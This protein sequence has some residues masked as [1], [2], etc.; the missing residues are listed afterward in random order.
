MKRYKNLDV[1]KGLMAILVIVSHSFF[2]KKYR[3]TM[4][5]FPVVIDMAVP[6]FLIISGYV[7]SYI[8]ISDEYYSKKNIFKKLLR[9]LLPF[10]GI[11]VGEVIYWVLSG[12]ESSRNIIINIVFPRWGDGGYY[13]IIMIQFILIF[14]QIY[15]LSKNIEGCTI[16]LGINIVSEAIL[17]GGGYL[18]RRNRMV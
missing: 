18:W 13:P 12:L 17:T 3:E 6:V 11:V 14:P 7:N 9:V 15:K 16:L 1:L 2:A 10:A 5:I 4:V 8:F